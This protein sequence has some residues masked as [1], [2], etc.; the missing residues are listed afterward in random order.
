M[1]H[2]RRQWPAAQ[3]APS[4][5]SPASA[6]RA[7][8]PSASPLYSSPPP[9]PGPSSAGGGGNGR[10]GHRRHHRL[11]DE[12]HHEEEPRQPRNRP[13]LPPPTAARDPSG[14]PAASLSW[15]SSVPWSVVRLPLPITAVMKGCSQLHCDGLPFVP[16]HRTQ[17]ALPPPPRGGAPI[18]VAHG[19][20]QRSNKGHTKQVTQGAG[21]AVVVVDDDVFFQ[22]AARMHLIPV[23]EHL[24]V[25]LPVSPPPGP[26]RPGGRRPKNAE[27]NT[28][29]KPS[30]PSD[31][32]HVEHVS[33]FPGA[34]TAGTSATGGPSVCCSVG[35][36]LCWLVGWCAAAY[37]SGCKSSRSGRAVEL[38]ESVERDERDELL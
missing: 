24:G 25:R 22:T 17:P 8:P 18:A 27:K 2:F 21:T 6:S 28:A 9:P 20:R 32:V 23:A 13:R 1:P 37:S 38:M 33:R 30:S 29:K 7:A 3:H 12:E 4:T 5:R 14:L 10:C 36:S 35:Q 19:N 11:G 34:N 26:Q 15:L 16:Q 31:E